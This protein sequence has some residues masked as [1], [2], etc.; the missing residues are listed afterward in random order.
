MHSRTLTV[1]TFKCFGLR[2]LKFKGFAT[3][4][5]FL[6]KKTIQ[7]PNLQGFGTVIEFCTCA[8]SHSDC[9]YRIHLL[10]H[11]SEQ[12]CTMTF[13]KGKKLDINTSLHTRVLWLAKPRLR[14][15]IAGDRVYK[16]TYMQFSAMLTVNMKSYEHVHH[17][18]HTSFKDCH[19]ISIMSVFILKSH[20]KDFLD[21]TSRYSKIWNCS[22]KVKNNNDFAKLSFRSDF[23]L[24]HQ[25]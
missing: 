3:T 18:Y 25:N 16:V 11:Y 22:L 13:L 5:K 21:W 6:T 20:E 10:S 23:P 19:T 15:N 7:V 24:L 14:N 17:S 8:Q 2:H 4:L 1:T 9:H 12:C